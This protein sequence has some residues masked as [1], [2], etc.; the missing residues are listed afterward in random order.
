MTHSYSNI[1]I[2]LIF[3]TKH[4]TRN[5]KPIIKSG[6]YGYMSGVFENI[7]C[8]PILINGA[9]DHV[10][11][12]FGLSPN[13][14]LA[15]VIRTIKTNSSKWVHENF[16]VFSHFGWQEGYAAFSV[17]ESKREHVIAYIQKQEEHHKK[18]SFVDEYVAFLK[19]HRIPFDE[20]FVVE[21]MED[22][23]IVGS[24]EEQ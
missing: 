9:S 20:R 1:L 5:I 17:S 12:L 3:S 18:Q 11:A 22:A 8:Y 6:L 14:A 7:D 13:Q 2:H 10:H 15:D 19:A 4:R 16:P 24:D 21:K 23:E